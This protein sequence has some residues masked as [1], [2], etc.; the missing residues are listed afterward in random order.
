MRRRIGV[1]LVLDLKLTFIRLTPYLGAFFLVDI[2][3]GDIERR[4]GVGCRR[5]LVGIKVVNPGLHALFL[6]QPGQAIVVEA[7]CCAPPCSRRSRW[8]SS[9]G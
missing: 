4:G 5:Y 7:L 8:N 1:T 3:L 2:A 6:G 9:A